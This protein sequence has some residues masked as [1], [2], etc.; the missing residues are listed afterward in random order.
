MMALLSFWMAPLACW[1]QTPRDKDTE[2]AKAAQDAYARQAEAEQNACYQ[3]AIM[4]DGHRIEVVANIGNVEEANAAVVAGGEG[5]GLLR[6]EFQF[7][8]RDTEPSE[9]E[10]YEAITAMIKAMN[11]LPMIIRTLD[12]GGDKD[13]PYL[14]TPE[15]MNPF[16]GVRGIRLCLLRDDIFRTAAAGHLP[17]FSAWTDP[18]HVSDDFI[19]G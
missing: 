10:Q 12:I 13:V 4:R 16:L 14:S 8:Q 3:P 18:H 15:E 17:S 2:Q 5:V 7:L 11:G 6:T 9:D 19:H 1:L